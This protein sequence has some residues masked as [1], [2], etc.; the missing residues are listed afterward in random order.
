MCQR[1]LLI[2]LLAHAQEQKREDIL[3]TS[4]NDTHTAYRG[5]LVHA[6]NIVDS[7]HYQLIENCQ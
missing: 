4:K 7:M 2:L 1:F 3:H 6:M 5:A